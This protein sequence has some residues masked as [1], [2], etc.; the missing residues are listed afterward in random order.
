MLGGISEPLASDYVLTSLSNMIQAKNGFKP[1][2][3][4]LVSLIS[5][6]ADS[7]TAFDKSTVFREGI[8]SQLQS[9]ANH[10][11]KIAYN[12]RYLLTRLPPDLECS[13]TIVLSG[14]GSLIKCVREAVEQ[15]LNSRLPVP[16][17]PIFSNVYGFYRMGKRLF[18]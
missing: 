18:G 6:K 9:A 8:D 16:S 3:E 15:Q 12:A 10:L 5:G 1:T 14:G 11:E 7:V 17:D 2:T 13:N 4:S